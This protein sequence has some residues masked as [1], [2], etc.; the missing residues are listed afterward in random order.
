[1]D[2]GDF[3]AGLSLIV[4]ALF[5]IFLYAI[6]AFVMFRG[7]EKTVGFRYLF[8]AAISGILLLFNYGV[9][10]GL[11]ILT[12][13]EITTESMRPWVHMYLDWVWFASCNHYTVVAW[14]RFVAVT[15]PSYFR[16]ETKVI[17]YSVCG[18]C[19]VAA[20]VLVL[21]TNFQPWYVTFY[22]EPSAYGMVAEDFGKYLKEALLL[23]SKEENWLRKVSR[24]RVKKQTLDKVNL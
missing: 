22:Y 7:S 16:R 14:S 18:C 13:S 20:L 23:Q 15:Y 10:P 5:F 8:S 9:W 17:S 2:G 6:V 24:W 1:M 12:K 11:V 3:F 19:Y 21:C 4:L